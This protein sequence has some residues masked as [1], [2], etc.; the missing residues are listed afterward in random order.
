MVLTPLGIGGAT[1]SMRAADI[2]CAGLTTS[3]PKRQKAAP[4]RT[5]LE[6]AIVTSVPPCS[7][8]RAGWIDSTAGA[9]YVNR[10][11]LLVK[12]RAFIVTSTAAWPEACAGARHSIVSLE[13]RRAGEIASEPNRQSSVPRV[14]ARAANGPPSTVTNVPPP[15]GP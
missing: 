1:H 10:T 2:H 5:M 4:P 12:S 13:M 9:R 14:A 6:P 3:P 15:T 11:P 8:P 7:G